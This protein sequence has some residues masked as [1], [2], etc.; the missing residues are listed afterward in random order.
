MTIIDRIE[1]HRARA[2]GESPPVCDC[3]DDADP[4]AWGN[5][6]ADTYELWGSAGD[7]YLRYTYYCCGQFIDWPVSDEAAARWRAATDTWRDDD[8][9][10]DLSRLTRKRERERR[11]IANSHW[12]GMLVGTMRADHE[13]RQRRERRCFVFA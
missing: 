3:L 13:D 4:W 9:E 12:N 2:S 7:Y 8:S 11:E 1:A 6:E 5:G 10:S